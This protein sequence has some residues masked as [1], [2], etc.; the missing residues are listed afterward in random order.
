MVIMALV[1]VWPSGQQCLL[2]MKGVAFLV[3]DQN[4]DDVIYHR[5]IVVQCYVFVTFT[6]CDDIVRGHVNVIGVKMAFSCFCYIFALLVPIYHLLR[7]CNDVRIKDIF[8]F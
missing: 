6:F 8:F 2:H 4:D 7:L 3:F 5:C 1:N